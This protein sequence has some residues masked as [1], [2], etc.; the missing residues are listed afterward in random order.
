MEN[1][2]VK[3]TPIDCEVNLQSSRG[4]T[5]QAHARNISL[6]GMYVTASTQELPVDSLVDLDFTLYVHGKV[7]HHHIP[8][9]VVHESEEGAGIMFC[10]FDPAA[11]RSMRRMLNSG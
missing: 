8:A 4:V 11:M 2:W 7:S 1:R 6:G 5:C 9:Q 10:D 3:R